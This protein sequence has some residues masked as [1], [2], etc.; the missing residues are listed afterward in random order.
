MN[1][2][3]KLIAPIPKRCNSNSIVTNA[4]P[5]P[6]PTSRFGGSPN[7]FQKRVRFDDDFDLRS[8]S[9]QCQEN[10]DIERAS[11][12]ILSILINDDVLST[13]SNTSEEGVRRPVPR[14]SNP[15]LKN[16]NLSDDEC[17]FVIVS[18]PTSSDDL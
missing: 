7:P 9:K 2:E 15:F 17:T 8:F 12:E 3:K 10:E 11:K 5:K 18:T 16:L 6:T 14:Q 13:H 1:N 4:I